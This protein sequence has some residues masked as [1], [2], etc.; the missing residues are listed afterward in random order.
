MSTIVVEGKTY[1]L[2]LR[3]FRCTLCDT[4]IE[5]SSPHPRDIQICFCGAL[6]LDG[7]IGAGATIN[8]TPSQMED[9]SVYTA[10]D[11]ATYQT[12]IDVK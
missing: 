9:L 8:G 11:G 4:T 12:R 3:R 10:A 6:L 2:T 1:T 7:G 5:T